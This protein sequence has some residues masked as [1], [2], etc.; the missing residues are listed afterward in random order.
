MSDTCSILVVILM[1]LCEEASLHLD[2]KSIVIDFKERGRGERER[3]RE[4]HPCERES[5]T[6]ASCTH[7]NWGLIPQLDI[8][9]DLESNPRPFRSQDN[10]PTH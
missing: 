6:V 5:S 7:P 10:A 3:K 2:W 1:R 4:E 8:Y 9:P